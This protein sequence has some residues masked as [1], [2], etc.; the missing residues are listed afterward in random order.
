MKDLFIIVGSSVLIASGA[1]DLSITSFS[2]YSGPDWIDET[3]L[4]AL[5]I[6]SRGSLKVGLG[7]IAL[8][9]LGHSDSSNSTSNSKNKNSK[10]QRIVKKSSKSFG[11][12]ILRKEANEKQVFEKLVELLEEKNYSKVIEDID[13]KKIHFNTPLFG[14]TELIIQDK[15]GDCLLILFSSNY[16]LKELIWQ[17]E[18]Y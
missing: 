12:F 15:N 10:Y 11:S 2:I 3:D 6:R 1:I 13:M 17:V 8:S 9:L 4:R 5:N 16:S 14:E 18:L 7:L